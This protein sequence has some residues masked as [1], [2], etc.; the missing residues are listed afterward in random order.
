M[1][2][3]APLYS[4]EACGTLGDVL[5]FSMRKSGPQVRYQRKQKDANT[6]AQNSIRDYFKLGLVLWN[7][8]PA[9][10]KAYWTEIDRK[11]Y[12]NV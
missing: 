1:K 4:V 12:A 10:E 2:I 5:T 6:T 9:E 7:S 8:L 3:K 11:G